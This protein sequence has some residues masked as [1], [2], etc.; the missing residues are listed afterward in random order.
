MLLDDEKQIRGFVSVINLEGLSLSQTA[1]APPSLL[2]KWV[3]ILQDCYL[4]RLKAIYVTNI[5]ST[6]KILFDIIKPFL[7]SKLLQRFRFLGSDPRTFH[8]LLPPDCIQ[9][10]FGSTHEDFDCSSQHKELQNATDYFE[11]INGCGF[12]RDTRHCEQLCNAALRRSGHSLHWL[13]GG[14]AILQN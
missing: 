11:H 7:K 3:H 12:R 9:A 8:G 2:K 6:Y 4:I 5:P 1:H 10:E 14:K 13:R